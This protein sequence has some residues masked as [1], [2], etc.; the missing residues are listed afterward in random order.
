MQYVN[1]YE[2]V[3]G[4]KRC[5]HFGQPIGLIYKGEPVF[6]TRIGGFCSL[7]VWTIIIWNLYLDVV[8]RH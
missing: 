7:I 1:L 3:R 8:H 5:D 4:L 2:R 6:Q